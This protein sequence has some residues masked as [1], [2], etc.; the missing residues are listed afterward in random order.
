MPTSPETT[1]IQLSHSVCAIKD[2]KRLYS[3]MILPRVGHSFVNYEFCK[4]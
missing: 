2:W 4:I 3:T 1:Q